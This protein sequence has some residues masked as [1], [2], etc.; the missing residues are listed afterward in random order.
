MAEENIRLYVQHFGENNVGILTVT[1]PSECLS[2]VAYQKMWHSW[3]THVLKELFPT[4]MWIRERQPR[5]GNWHSH[6]V[7]DLGWDI[8]TGFPFGEVAARNYKNVD[9][10][11]KDIWK[12]LR[13]SAVKYGFG[14]T[15]LLPIKANGPSCARYLVKYLTKVR[16]SDK[17]QGEEKCRLFGIWGGVRFIS[18][19]FS[20][21]RSRILRK[22]KAWLAA[23]LGIECYAGFKVVFGSHWWHHLGAALSDV[24]MPIEY[25]QVP[26]NGQM[27]WDDLG[28]KAYIADLAKFPDCSPETAMDHSWHRMFWA[29]GMWMFK[30]DEGQ[31][32]NMLSTRW[33]G[34]RA[35]FRKST[36]SFSCNSPPSQKRRIDPCSPE[37]KT[38]HCRMRLR[39]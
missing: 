21:T 23:M 6:S 13:E 19:P 34:V 17:L 31:V 1:T 16:G 22:R 5:T 35:L 25:Y 8:K 29:V 3:R 12:T 32:R 28:F 27:V 9:P 24:V 20:Y 18:T 7:I 33:L 36:R 10:R 11:L 15:E 4:G 38:V 26:E 37:R 39:S 2:A 14:R 30:G